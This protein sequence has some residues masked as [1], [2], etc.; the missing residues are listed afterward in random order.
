MGNHVEGAGLTEMFG[1]GVCESISAIRAI[2]YQLSLGGVLII[3]RSKDSEFSPGMWE[4]P[5]G[6]IDRGAMSPYMTGFNEF[7]TETGIPVLIS[8]N[9]PVYIWSKPAGLPPKYPGHIRYDCTIVRAHLLYPTVRKVKLSSEHDDYQW[10][11]PIPEALIPFGDF[12]PKETR[13]A[14]EFFYIHYILLP[15]YLMGMR[16]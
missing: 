2:L 13:D 16:Q 12:L 4:L 14:L 10:V 5:G 15:E 7:Y 11:E 1:S 3:R 8:M 9:P 6:K